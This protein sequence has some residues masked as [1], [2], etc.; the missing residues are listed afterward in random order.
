MKSNRILYRAPM[1]FALAT[2]VALLAGCG[3][4]PTTTRTTVTEQTTTAVPPPPVETT[5]TTT[6]QQTHQ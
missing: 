1:A 2:A 6:T 3:S 5:T 4:A